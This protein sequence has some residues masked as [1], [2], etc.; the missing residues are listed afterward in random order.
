[1]LDNSWDNVVDGGPTLNKHRLNVSLFSGCH[2]GCI[3][4]LFS[5]NNLQPLNSPYFI[6]T[7]ISHQN[8]SI[9]RRAACKQFSHVGSIVK[10]NGQ[11]NNLTH[12]IETNHKRCL[13]QWCSLLATYLHNLIIAE[14]HKM[15]YVF[16]ILADILG[17]DRHFGV[18]NSEVE[19]AYLIQLLVKTLFCKY[20]RQLVNVIW[21][22]TTE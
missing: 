19:L 17:K 7:A 12:K 8:G 15:F 2:K 18:A 21:L 1:M 4:Q 20:K 3:L 10:I 16:L 14:I 13:T 22:Y 6:C 9:A 11:I 5:F